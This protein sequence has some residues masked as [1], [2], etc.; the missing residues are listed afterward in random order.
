MFQLWVR[1]FKNHHT[2]QEIVIADSSSRTRTQKVFHS[3]E[4]ACVAFDLSK[5]IWLDA[6]ISDFKKYCKAR[7]TQDC[8]IEPIEF[9]YLEIQILEED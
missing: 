5:P 9:D 4:E 6:T 7:F 3:L 2:V 8:F 1:E